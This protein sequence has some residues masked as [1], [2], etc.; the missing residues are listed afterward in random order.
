MTVLESGADAYQGSL[1]YWLAQIPLYVLLGFSN[2][3]FSAVSQPSNA[4]LSTVLSQVSTP[5]RRIV[6]EILAPIGE[7]FAIFGLVVVTYKLARAEGASKTWSLVVAVSLG[8]GIFASLHGVR[9]F[10]F[11]AM[12]FIVM[13]VM[14]GSLVAEDV[15]LRQFDY[16]IVT[17]G[18]TIGFHR[19]WN[20]LGAGGPLSFYEAVLQAQPPVIYV[21]Y[22]VLLFDVLTLAI[23]VIGTVSYLRRGE[24]PLPTGSN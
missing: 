20:Q 3:Q 19:A 7:N 4:Y 23:V 14:A 6:N 21:V 8:S 22:P 18:A 15:G 9:S 11:F 5:V 2:I 1:A 24:N 13:A 16:I 17:V 10:T 12:A